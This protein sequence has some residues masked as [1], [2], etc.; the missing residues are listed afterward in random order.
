M[1]SLL[2]YKLQLLLKYLL[3][4][5]TATQYWNIF[6]M[7]IHSTLALE[8]VGGRILESIFLWGK[9]QIHEGQDQTSVLL[10]VVIMDV[11]GNVEDFIRGKKRST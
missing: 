9:N 1:Y 11:M 4:S 3:L 7:L 6:E 10:S 5:G 8:C 2:V